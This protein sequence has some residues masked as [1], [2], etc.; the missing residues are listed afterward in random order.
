MITFKNAPALRAAAA[1]API[2]QLLVETD[3]PFL[4]PH[5]YR[6]TPQRAAAAAADRAGAGRAPA[7]TTLDALCAA[8]AA[9]GIR[10]FG[11]IDLAAV[12]AFTQMLAI[13]RTGRLGAPAA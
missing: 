6:G 9:T 3:A 4:T 12:A 11:A 2:E 5:P 13:A 8:I 7:A 10:L 1:V